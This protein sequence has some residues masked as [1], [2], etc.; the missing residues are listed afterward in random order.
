MMRRIKK[1]NILQNIL[2]ICHKLKKKTKTNVI[3]QHILSIF[4]VVYDEKNKGI[5]HIAK[6]TLHLS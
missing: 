6:Y 4:E 3:D 1:L 5:K 2:A